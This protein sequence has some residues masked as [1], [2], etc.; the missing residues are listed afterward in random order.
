MRMTSI[1]ISE[2]SEAVNASKLT[3]DEGKSTRQA[4]QSLPL[5]V[6]SYQSF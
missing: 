1:S 6:I 3:E 5:D 4:Q 2:A